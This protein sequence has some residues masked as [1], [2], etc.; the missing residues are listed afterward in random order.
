M[1][2]SALQRKPENLESRAH[3]QANRGREQ[4]D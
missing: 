2:N 3:P 4:S 1:Q